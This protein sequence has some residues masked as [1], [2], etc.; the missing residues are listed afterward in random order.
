M[1]D[2]TRAKS[3]RKLLNPVFH[4]QTKQEDDSQLSDGM[5]KVVRKTGQLNLSGRGMSSGAIGR[6]TTNQALISIA[7]VL[8]PS[9]MFTMYN[10]DKQV[11]FVDYNLDR[12]EDDT[13]WSYKPLTYLDLSS[14]VLREIPGEISMFEDLTELNVRVYVSVEVE[15]CFRT[16]RDN[17]CICSFKIIA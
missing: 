1:A 12:S 3:R 9:K 2:Q 17:I 6:S 15:K 4:F 10:S 14:N 16:S 5:I 7:S 8:V 11:G 13:W